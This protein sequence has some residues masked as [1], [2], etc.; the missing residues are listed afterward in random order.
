MGR[1]I[2]GC[3]YGKV[4]EMS[5]GETW[6]WGGNQNMC[7]LRK[8]DFVPEAVGNYIYKRWIYLDLC[9]KRD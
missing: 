3:E 8:S 9:F 5:S 2:W 6:S 7:Q 4:S 1:W